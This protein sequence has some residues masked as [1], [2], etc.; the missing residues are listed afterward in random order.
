MCS[1]EAGFAWFQPCPPPSHL[2]LGSARDLFL[3]STSG[4][5]VEKGPTDREIKNGTSCLPLRL[6][7]KARK[8]RKKGKANE[9]QRSKQDG[10]RRRRRPSTQRELRGGQGRMKMHLHHASKGSSSEARKVKDF[11]RRA[12][13][14]HTT[15]FSYY[16]SFM[17]R[18]RER[19]ITQ[20]TTLC[21]QLIVYVH[22]MIQ[23]RPIFLG[24]VSLFFYLSTLSWLDYPAVGTDAA[25]ASV[26]LDCMVCPRSLGQTT[27]NQTITNLCPGVVTA[28]FLLASHHLRH[29]TIRFCY[30]CS[31]SFS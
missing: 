18:E 4:Q 5:V 22:W 31:D 1:T 11:Q 24:T 21:A 19:E 15:S 30:G 6:Q 2:I 29:L 27:R 13:T 3:F 8:K 26:Q 17:G 12:T 20:W 25:G 14:E 23:P 7:R 16:L 28:S 9:L 10:A